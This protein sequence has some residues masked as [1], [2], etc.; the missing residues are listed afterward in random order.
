MSEKETVKENLKNLSH[1]DLVK[2]GATLVIKHV[3]DGLEI[4]QKNKGREQ[5]DYKI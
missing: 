4:D 3:A 5:D 2:L 1:D